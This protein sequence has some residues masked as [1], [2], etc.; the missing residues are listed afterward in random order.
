[1]RRL[2]ALLSRALG[3]LMIALV[4]LYQ[5]TLSPLLGPRCR[6]WPSCSA[7]TAEALRV[8]GPLRGAWLGI[9]RIAR[10]HPGGAGG[11]DPVPGGPSEQ[12]C[13]EDPELD[14]NFYCRP[15]HRPQDPR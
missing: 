8:H 9:K 10:C 2:L 7:Y 14:E 11:I 12:L 6:Y 13:R 3:G 1:M 5:V 15:P 4:R